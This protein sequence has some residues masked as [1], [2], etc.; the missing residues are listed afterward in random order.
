MGSE[1]LMCMTKLCHL[2]TIK[3]LG[4]AVCSLPIHSVVDM[5]TLGG[6]YL[7]HILSVVALMKNFFMPLCN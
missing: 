1:E 5:T 3:T 2:A 6:E 7:F 4:K